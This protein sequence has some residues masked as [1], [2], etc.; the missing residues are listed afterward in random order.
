[1][2][3]LAAEERAKQATTWL[4]TLQE[5]NR[6]LQQKLDGMKVSVHDL[7]GGETRQPL[8]GAEHVPP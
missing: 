5:L 3:R 6:E 2:L 7:V 4:Q 1:V 8:A